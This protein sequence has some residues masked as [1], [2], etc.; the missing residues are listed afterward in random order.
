M[1]SK[2]P[3]PSDAKQDPPVPCDLEVGDLVTFTN[4][5]GVRF[6]N[7]VV[8]GFAPVVEHGRYVYLDIDSWWFPVKPDELTKTPEEEFEASRFECLSQFAV[9]PAVHVFI[10]D[11]P[12][13]YRWYEHGGKSR[14]EP[15]TQEELAQYLEVHRGYGA[16]EAKEAARIAPLAV[17]WAWFNG[18][19]SARKA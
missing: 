6:P 11:T 9:R 15:L 14:D 13:F 1:Q 2:Y 5:Y 3:I 16:R 7:H 17:D 4:D 19:R 10:E 18:E 12:E 8:V